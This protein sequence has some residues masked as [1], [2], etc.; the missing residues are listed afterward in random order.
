MDEFNQKDAIKL[1]AKYTLEEQLSQRD[2]IHLGDIAIQPEI[3]V[4]PKQDMDVV[5]KEISHVMATPQLLKYHLLQYNQRQ[6]DFFREVSKH[7]EYWRDGLNFSHFG[8][9][10]FNGLMLLYFNDD[11]LFCVMPRE[12][13]TAFQE[14]EQT[15]FPAEWDRRE[16]V[17]TYA[18]AATELYGVIRISDFIEIFNR[19][20]AEPVSEKELLTAISDESEV[21]HLVAEED[22]LFREI[23][24]DDAD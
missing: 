12:I 3:N 17:R 23:C 11:R 9:P 1:Q 14:L 21:D 6:M 18:R 5:I 15:T 20:N 7:D 2:D 10:H 13:R 8:L 16:L 19:Q 4:N 24:F 22:Y